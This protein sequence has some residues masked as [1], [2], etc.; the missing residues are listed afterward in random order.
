MRKEDQTAQAQIRK[1]KKI[2]WN[3][4]QQEQFDHDANMATEHQNAYALSAMEH[5]TRDDSEKIN[6]A[7][8][9]GFWC[10]VY[11][12]EVCCR[13]TDGLLGI[14]T[15]LAFSSRSLDAVLDWLD[16]GESEDTFILAPE[17]I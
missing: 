6:A 2:M 4:Q 11:R 5:Q 15:I 1:G 17:K 14:D 7:S 9:A 12:F 10:V 13:Y 16:A 8:R 3:I